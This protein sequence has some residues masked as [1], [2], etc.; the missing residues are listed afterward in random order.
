M[1]SKAWQ[2]RALLHID[3]VK[4]VIEY[5][6]ESDYSADRLVRSPLGLCAR[7]GD[8]PKYVPGGSC[9]EHC[10]QTWDGSNQVFC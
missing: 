7:I 5:L 2:P 3:R 6:V 4:I 10:C 9:C 8:Q 1:M